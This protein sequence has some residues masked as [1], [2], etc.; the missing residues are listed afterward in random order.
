MVSK[1][2]GAI[3]LAGMGCE[4]TSTGRLVRFFLGLTA[5]ISGREGKIEESVRS[6]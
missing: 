6:R 4:A 1:I 5:P 3:A 2:F